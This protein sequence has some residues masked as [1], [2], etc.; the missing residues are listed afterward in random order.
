[1]VLNKIKDLT[2]SVAQSTLNGITNGKFIGTSYSS[3][4]LS[5]HPFDPLSSA[6]IERAVAAV[7]KEKGDA[8]HFNAIGLQE[9]RKAEM[10]AWLQEAR[11]AL[12]SAETNANGS[13]TA[14]KAPKP[15]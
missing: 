12:A 7:R 3:I 13:T 9:P 1:M 10:L 14:F 15:K 6:E 4:P 2:T 5:T 11:H 8:L